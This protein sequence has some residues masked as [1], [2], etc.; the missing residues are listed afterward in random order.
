M[1]SKLYFRIQY[2]KTNSMAILGKIRQRSFFLILVIGLALFAFVISGAFGNGSGDTGPNEPIGVVNGEEIPLENFRLL[3]DQTERTYGYTTLQAV[4]TVWNQ[5]VRNELFQNEF[6][7]L[8]IDAGKDQIEQVVSSTESI[9]TD[10]RFINEAGF[11]DFGLFTDF[12]AQMRDTNPQAYETWKQQ[13]AGIIA[14]ARESIYFD[15]IQSSLTVTEQEAKMLYHLEADN[16]DLNYVQIP[17]AS[18]AD[19]L[20]SVKESEVKAYIKENAS[21]YEREASRSLQYISFLEQATEEDQTIIRNDLE[22]LVED[23]IEY[24]DV[25]KLTD[26][27]LGFQNTQTLVI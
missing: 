20:F 26:T 14:S 15:L 1:Q 25:S 12:I 13:E 24:N 19:T 18:L 16:V 6:D 5:F 3:V 10:T 7:I 9:I 17:Y 23:R 22:A 21:Q 4:Q 8:G 11:F 27:I 2:K